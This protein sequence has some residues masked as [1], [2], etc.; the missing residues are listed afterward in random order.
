VPDFF[1]QSIHTLT[2]Q[3][4]R[5]VQLYIILLLSNSKIWFWKY[6]RWL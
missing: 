5:T 3:P 2:I 1:A 4:E 6:I